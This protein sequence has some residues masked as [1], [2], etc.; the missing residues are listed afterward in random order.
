MKLR[1]K[2]GLGLMVFVGDC[3]CTEW[4]KVHLFVRQSV[5]L[6]LRQCQQFQRSYQALLHSRCLLDSWFITLAHAC[7][8]TYALCSCYYMF[9]CCLLE[10]FDTVI[11]SK[12][13]EH[14][15]FFGIAES[16]VLTKFH[17]KWRTPLL[18]SDCGQLNF[19]KNI[20]ATPVQNALLWNRF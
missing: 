18:F 12:F 1:T 7:Y 15:N 13:S 16:A 19:N 11:A 5:P 9:C 4:H 17:L 3:D 8:L 10:T 14:L 2:P 20:S 6:L